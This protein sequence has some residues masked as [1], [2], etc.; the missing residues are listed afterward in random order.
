MGMKT[1]TIEG[2]GGLTGGDGGTGPHYIPTFGDGG[3]AGIW[4]PG[5]VAP[6]I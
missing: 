5:G 1:G 6:V 2:W 4:P 3:T